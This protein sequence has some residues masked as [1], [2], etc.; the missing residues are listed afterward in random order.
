MIHKLLFLL[1]QKLLSIQFFVA[2]L[3]SPSFYLKQLRFRVVDCKAMTSPHL[4]IF[5][6]HQKNDLPFY[7]KNMVEALIANA[8]N[9]F[10]G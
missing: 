9:D 7:V 2:D 5:V 8:R 4:A 10:L 3:L 1:V 6:V